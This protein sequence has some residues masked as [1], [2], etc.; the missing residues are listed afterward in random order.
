MKILVCFQ[1]TNEYEPLTFEEWDSIAHGRNTLS[2]TKSAIDKVD[3]AGIETALKLQDTCPADKEVG[4]DVVTVANS[5]SKGFATV[6]YAAGVRSVILL[7]N[8]SDTDIGAVAVS[9]AVCE[10][11]REEQYDLVFAGCQSSRNEGCKTGTLISEI[12]G[13]KSFLNV[14]SITIERDDGIKAVCRG[15]NGVVTFCAPMPAVCLMD[16]MCPVYLR[17]PTLKERLRVKDREIIV[18]NTSVKR[19]ECNDPRLVSLSAVDRRRNCIMLKCDR[20]DDMQKLRKIIMGGEC[21]E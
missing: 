2:L 11:V 4:V 13:W 7:K 21:N 6:L 5:L 9:E 16:D 8:S 17:V 10:L 20:Q 12:L 1:I 15:S 18:G 19:A 14:Q 3:E